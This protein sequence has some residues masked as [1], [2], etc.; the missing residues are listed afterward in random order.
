MELLN[1]IVY[2]TP[3]GFLTKDHSSG[4]DIK[5]PRDVFRDKSGTCVDLAITYAA[6]AESV[7]LKANLMVVPGHTFAV[8]RLPGG[9]YLPVENTGLGGGNQRMTFQQAVDAGK[10]ELQKYAEDGVFYLV[11]VEDQ[12]NSQRIPNPELQQVANDFLGKSGIRPLSELASNNSGGG[13]SRSAHVSKK[14]KREGGNGLGTPFR[15]VHD[16]AM[17]M[18]SAWCV[19]TLYVSADTVTFVPERA[20]DGRMDRFQIRKSDIREAKKNKMPLGQNGND[21]QGFHIR[22]ANGSNYN[23]A[24][25]DEQGRGLPADDVLIQLLQ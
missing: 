21:L 25:V 8:I 17:G 4:Q 9:E 24:R 11:N 3:S 12:W 2:S 18:L 1:D 23:F 5:Y 14:E 10:K 6:L 22:L 7:G 16:H 13:P 20:T 19:G 15:V